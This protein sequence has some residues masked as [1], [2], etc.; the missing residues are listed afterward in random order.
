MALKTEKLDEIRQKIIDSAAQRFQRFG[1]G[2]TNV[3][4]IACDCGMSAGNLY[5]YFKNKSQ[6]A[7]AIMR[8]SLDSTLAELK[9]VLDLPD[10]TA[11]KRLEEFF[12]Q[13]LYFTH[14]QLNTYPTLLE[15]V[16]DPNGSGPMLGEEYLE[17]SRVLLVQILSMGVEQG[18]FQIDDLEETAKTIQA[19]TLKFRYSQLHTDQTLEEL[20]P[21]AHGV[22]NLILR[23]LSTSTESENSVAA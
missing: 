1:Y 20:E 5:R 8:M 10:I 17:A 16:R 9:S 11:A 19:A 15:H 3:A 14:H 6:I 13:E 22:I 2:K 7:E 12:L 21:S 4:E 23:A 18:E